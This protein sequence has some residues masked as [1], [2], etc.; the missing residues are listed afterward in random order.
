MQYR[1]RLAGCL[2]IIDPV[3]DRLRKYDETE[4]RFQSIIGQYESCIVSYSNV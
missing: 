1:D 2:H 3:V 4:I